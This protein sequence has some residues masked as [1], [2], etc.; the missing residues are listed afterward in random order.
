MNR[1]EKLIFNLGTLK[2]KAAG[3][4]IPQEK[5]YEHSDP[6]KNNPDNL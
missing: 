5:L 4:L 2:E 3:D 1:H 6:A